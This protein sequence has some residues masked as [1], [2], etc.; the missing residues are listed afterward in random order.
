MLRHS[1]FIQTDSLSSLS[2]QGEW[3]PLILESHDVETQRRRLSLDAW[4]IFHWTSLK[5]RLSIWIQRLDR[6]DVLWQLTGVSSPNE[7]WLILVP[8]HIPLITLTCVLFFTKALRPGSP[9]WDPELSLNHG[10][11]FEANLVSR[12]QTCLVWEHLFV[13]WRVTPVAGCWIQLVFVWPEIRSQWGF[14]QGD[15]V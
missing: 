3:L 8:S 4:W 10:F 6:G 11:R 5:V 7:L 14:Y 2:H 15:W 13:Q 12:M 9:L 1:E